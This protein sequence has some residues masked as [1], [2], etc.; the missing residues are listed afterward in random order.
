MIND[1][2]IKTAWENVVL[3]NLP[4]GEEVR[5]EVLR[6]WIRCREIGL[7]DEEIKNYD[8]KIKKDGFSTW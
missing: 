3:K 4:P 2:D 5:P 6:S 7:S 1:N 8:I